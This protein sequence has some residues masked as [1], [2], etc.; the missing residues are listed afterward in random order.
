MKRITISCSILTLLLLGSCTATHFGFFSGSTDFNPE[1]RYAG[2]VSGVASTS[3]FLGLGGIGKQALAAEARA[4]M[5]NKFPMRDGLRLTNFTTDIKTSYILCFIKRSLILTAD[6]IDLTQPT[7]PFGLKNGY[8]LNDSVFIE[9]STLQNIVSEKRLTQ[10]EVLP[11][12]LR[13]NL[14]TMPDNN[15]SVNVFIL[16][17][18]MIKGKLFPSNLHY[19]V[20][21]RTNIDG[22]VIYVCKQ[23]FN[24]LYHL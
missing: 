4:N 19:G 3:Y 6:M 17:K 18:K 12:D 5:L 1:H 10:T 20:M 9:L 8:F 23:P 24:Y 22:K 21:V 16:N 7:L 14:L 2:S 11:S 15:D 13:D